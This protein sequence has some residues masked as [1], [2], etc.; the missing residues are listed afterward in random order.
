MLP[1]VN[2]EDYEYTIKTADYGPSSRESS[3]ILCSPLTCR[4]PALKMQNSDLL[5]SAHD[6]KHTLKS[7]KKFKAEFPVINNFRLKYWDALYNYWLYVWL[8]IM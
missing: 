2:A 5:I 1:L 4:S 3:E 8:T 6:Q 7:I